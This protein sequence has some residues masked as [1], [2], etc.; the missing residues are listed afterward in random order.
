MKGVFRHGRNFLPFLEV[1]FPCF[2]GKEYCQNSVG[3]LGDWSKVRVQRIPETSGLGI[4][5]RPAQNMV[6]CAPPQAKLFPG[7]IFVVGADTAK[8]IVDPKYYGN[9]LVTARFSIKLHYGGGG[10]EC[11]LIVVLDQRR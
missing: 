3:A 1:T 7:C 9:S 4:L 10:I 11:F 8:R 2:S 6:F 5:T